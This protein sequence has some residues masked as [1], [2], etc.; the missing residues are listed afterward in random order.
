MYMKSEPMIHLFPT[1]RAVRSFYDTLK[2]TDC[3]LPFALPIAEFQSKAMIIPHRIL[4]DEDTR[5]LLMQ[6]AAN[7]ST[8]AALHIPKEFMAFLRNSEYLFRFFEELVAEERGFDDL[9][10]ADT[11]AEF[12]EHLTLLRTLK[13]RYEALLEQHRLYDRITLPALYELNHAYLQ[14]IKS[15]HLHLEGYL[16]RFELAFLKKIALVIPV[17]ISLHVNTYSKKMVDIFKEEGIAIEGKGLVHF[18]LG[19]KTILQHTPLPPINSSRLAKGVASRSLQVGYLFHQLSLM[20]QEGISPERIAIV[21]PDESFVPLLK[22]FDRANNLNFAMGKSFEQSMVFT[23]LKAMELAISEE[24]VETKHRLKRLEIDPLHVRK[25]QEAWQ[26]IVD[27]KTFKQLIDLGSVASKEEQELFNEEMFRLERLLEKRGGLRF[28]Q[29]LQLLLRRLKALSLDDVQGGRVTVMGV[30][31]TRGM[32]FD[33][34]LIPDFNDDLVP[35]RS[36]KDMFLSSKLRK[37][38]GLPTAQDRENLQRYFYER[39]LN[40]AQKVVICY[41]KSE[42]KLPARFLNYLQVQED[43][44][45]DESVYASLLMDASFVPPP[46][47]CKDI[48]LE[49]DLFAKPLSASR[50]KSFL[51]CARRYYFRYIKH[52][53]EFK[54]PDDM[55]E[56]S[57][58]GNMIHLALEKLYANGEGIS[59]ESGVLERRL[60]NILQEITPPSLLWRLESDI[61]HQRLKDFCIHEIN[62]AHEGW[63]PW[64]GEKK[65]TVLF[66]GIVLEGKIDRL[67]RHLDGRI[68]VLDYKTGSFPNPTPRNVESVID[69]QMEFYWLLASTLG[70][71]DHVGYYDLK[72]VCVVMEGKMEEKLERLREII[73]T[74]QKTKEINFEMT[75][76]RSE[77]Q[78]CPYVLLCG[79]E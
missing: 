54:E 41:V 55:L 53:D 18:D 1:S 42:E 14:E 36:H 65:L 57:D 75:D 52:F 38:A 44:A 23:H 72:E 49:H 17:E 15:V 74:Y 58:I 50:L 60:V 77:C 29:L 26:S 32:H 39:L 12:G 59:Q 40:Q 30:L 5:L 64:L 9:E 67:D 22:R 34:V 7:F 33:G 28:Y 56:A 37:H 10:G 62:R 25:W 70:R 63:Q 43:V 46:F 19:T 73:Q 31:E 16:S 13:Q 45:Y 3:L 61:W 69:F 79:R 68:A 21:L 11:Y 78:Y 6:E 47:T 35:K 51:G 24:T 66:E 76:K 8:F 71:V 20:I 48:I 27:F 2:E 4:A